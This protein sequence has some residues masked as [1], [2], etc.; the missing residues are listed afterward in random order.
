MGFVL[1][2]GLA[3]DP[4]RNIEFSCGRIEPMGNDRTSVELQ[5]NVWSGEAF[6]TMLV[7]FGSV[8]FEKPSGYRY[9]VIV[10]PAELE[11]AMYLQKHIA[12]DLTPLQY[13]MHVCEGVALAFGNRRKADDP[14][15]CTVAV[16]DDALS[17]V[18]I[19][20]PSDMPMVG[21][22]YVLA[23]SPEEAWSAQSD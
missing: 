7:V 20:V 16:R 18:G 4:Q 10:T 22:S 9:R 11:L 15:E 2:G 8:T 12:P 1:K 14:T 19:A 3:H 23:A 13:V 17:A 21:G 5:V 6:V